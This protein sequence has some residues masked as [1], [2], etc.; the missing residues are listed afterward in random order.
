MVLKS[1]T[2]FFPFSFTAHLHCLKPFAM[3]PS[4]AQ[5][6]NSP[7]L[8]CKHPA[9]RLSKGSLSVLVRQ[10][11]FFLFVCF[12][13]FDFSQFRFFVHMADWFIVFAHSVTLT[14]ELHRTPRR[15][16]GSGRAGPHASLCRPPGGEAD[17]PAGIRPLYSGNGGAHPGY[18]QQSEGV[19]A[20][21]LHGCRIP[22]QLAAGSRS[23]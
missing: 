20:L 18:C 15:G 23:R 5:T 9:T 4:T 11:F 1:E 8:T 10:H 16:P 12:L 7:C 13:L 3:K 14:S 19:G 6:I 2:V 21:L 17:R 22:V